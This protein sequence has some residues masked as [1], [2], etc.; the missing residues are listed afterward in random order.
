MTRRHY[1]PILRLVDAHVLMGENGTQHVDWVELAI[2]PNWSPEF[3]ELP[4]H[5]RMEKYRMYW[6]KEGEG[7]PEVIDRDWP[8]SRGIQRM[9]RLDEY[10]WLG[11]HSAL[12]GLLGAVCLVPGDLAKR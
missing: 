12:G 4:E 6:G 8:Y 9:L 3:E 1:T 5:E 7:M 10:G 2:D 11:W